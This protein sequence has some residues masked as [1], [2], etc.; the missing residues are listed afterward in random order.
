MPRPPKKQR[1][2]AGQRLSQL[3]RKHKLTFTQLLRHVAAQE[4]AIWKAADCFSTSLTPCMPCRCRK[5]LDEWEK[6]NASAPDQPHDKH[7]AAEPE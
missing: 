6:S 1:T 7:P 5:L 3:A 4:C 2:L